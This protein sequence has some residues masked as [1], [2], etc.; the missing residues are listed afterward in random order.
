MYLFANLVKKLN[1]SLFKSAVYQLL[2]SFSGGILGLIFWILAAKI[3][4]TESV[5]IASAVI[6]SI[7][8]I[9]Q[10]SRIGLDQTI[11]GYISEYDP[12]RLFFSTLILSTCIG[13]FFSIIYVILCT[14]FKTYTLDI[15]TFGFIVIIFATVGSITTMCGITFIAVKRTE[16][17]F[18]QSL[19]LG[20]RIIFLPFFVFLNT[21]GLI[22]S[23]VLAYLFGLIYSVYE[24]LKL[25]MNKVTFDCAILKKSFHFSIANYIAN[26]S[27]TAPSQLLPIIVLSIYGA[28]E[29]AIFF[30]S[31]S[32]GSIFFNI[33]NAIHYSLFSERS[34]SK[35]IKN[36]TI[37][38][39]KYL[40]S[41]LIPILIIVFLFAQDLF[42]FIGKE[43][44]ANFNIVYLIAISSIPFGF[45]QIFLSIMKIKRM[46]SKIFL[47]N[48]LA[49]ILIIFSSIVFM[50]NF[51]IIG[52]GYAWIFTYSFS[53]IGIF[54]YLKEKNIL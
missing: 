32:I 51:G 1:D 11:I 10:L 2:T 39:I 34:S 22:V 18:Y 41:F 8:L 37:K 21:W 44:A 40:F 7:I 17:Y 52:I 36:D 5:G 30:I 46:V 3:Y 54:I 42:K 26:I 25:G 29:T 47:S 19:C 15:I 27:T 4:P 53:S 49:F 9:I 43:Y 16:L 24:I 45:F 20:A 12:S 6:A 13:V 48:L 28:T 14:F 31:F 38:S 23:F 35:E 33:P 50:L